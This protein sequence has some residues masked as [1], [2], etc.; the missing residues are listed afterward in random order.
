MHLWPTSAAAR[1]QHSKR[2]AQLES[3]A[4]SHVDVA[5]ALAM[6]Q[7]VWCCSGAVAVFHQQERLSMTPSLPLY[8]AVS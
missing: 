7:H 4:V 6:H 1:R 5:Y 2:A 8:I 3:C